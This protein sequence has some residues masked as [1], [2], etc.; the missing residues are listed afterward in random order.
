MLQMSMGPGLPGQPRPMGG[1]SPGMP[2][3]GIPDPRLPPP[4]MRPGM[5]TATGNL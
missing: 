2:P 1:P 4:G 5:S 3:R